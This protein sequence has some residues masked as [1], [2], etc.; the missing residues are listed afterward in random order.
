MRERERER[1]GNKRSQ[2]QESSQKAIFP[3]FFDAKKNSSV[4]CGQK[5]L[6][7]GLEACRAVILKFEEL[8]TALENAGV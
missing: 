1:E 2:Y 6:S 3:S 5:A 7:G 4:T 8:E